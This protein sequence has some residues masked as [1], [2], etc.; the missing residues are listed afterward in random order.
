MDVTLIE[1]M[2]TAFAAG[3][4]WEQDHYARKAE[5]SPDDM[6]ESTLL[7]FCMPGQLFKQDTRRFVVASLKTAFRKGQETER[8]TREH[9]KI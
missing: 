8:E 3:I 4:S 9:A 6:Q 7:A 2:K 1:A 5:P